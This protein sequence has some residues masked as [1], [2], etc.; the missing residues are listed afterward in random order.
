MNRH[1]DI[2]R[3]FTLVELLVVIAVIAILAALLLPAL[4]KAKEKGKLAVCTNNERQLSIAWQLYAGDNDERLV[5][6][7]TGEVYSPDR[8]WLP[9]WVS[10]AFVS[11]VDCTNAELLVNP[12]YALFANYIRAVDVYKCP[13]SRQ[14]SRSSDAKPLE[15]PISRNY[16]LN[17]WL[18]PEGNGLPMPPGSVY[19]DLTAQLSTI[20]RCVQFRKM[21]QVVSPGASLLFTFIDAQPDSICAP[22]YQAHMTGIGS[23]VIGNY[24]AA[25]HNRRAV[26]SF[27]DGHTDIHRWVDPRTVAAAS[28]NFHSHNDSSPNNLDVIWLEEHTTAKR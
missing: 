18:A 26:I 19:D 3:A 21:S 23:E 17:C 27:A 14:V 28:R 9:S 11:S 25:H 10:G 2:A 6:N 5:R 20:G 1:A 12:R 7:G 22:M 15:I 16:E 24:P 4:S 8:G 13:A